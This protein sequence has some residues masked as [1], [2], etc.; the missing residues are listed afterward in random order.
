MSSLSSTTARPNKKNFLFNYI[1]DAFD[2]KSLNLTNIESER[3]KYIDRSYLF[4]DVE[5][6]AINTTNNDKVII[7]LIAF[8]KI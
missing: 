8:F 6:K 5:M 2:S 4:V 3:H 7:R 1:P